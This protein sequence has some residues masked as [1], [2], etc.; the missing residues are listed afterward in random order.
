MLYLRL[1]LKFGSYVNS[2][3]EIDMF[4]CLLS[5]PQALPVLLQSACLG[6]LQGRSITC[7][8]LAIH[9]V[10]PSPPPL[11]D[12]ADSA[13][14]QGTLPSNSQV[15]HTAGQLRLHRLQWLLAGQENFPSAVA[16]H[17][18]GFSTSDAAQ[19]CAAAAS[20]RRRRRQPNTETAVRDAISS[21]AQRAEKLYDG[22]SHLVGVTRPTYG[23][24]GLWRCNITVKLRKAYVNFELECLTHLEAAVACDLL[25]CAVYGA[26]YPANFPPHLYPPQDVAVMKTHLQATVR[27]SRLLE[28]AL[29]NSAYRPP[30]RYQARAAGRAADAAVRAA[31]EAAGLSESDVQQRTVTG[32]VVVQNNSFVARQWRSTAV[33]EVTGHETESHASVRMMQQRCYNSMLQA[34]VAYD[35]MRQALGRSAVNF[36]AEVTS[37]GVP[38]MR[39]WMDLD[40]NRQ[41]VEKQYWKNKVTAAT[42]DNSGQKPRG[43]ASRGRRA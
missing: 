1:D 29:I 19:L 23:G 42:S 3:S 13:H 34:A 38:V 14:Q 21:L 40:M 39:K 12:T 35:M 11:L 43:A 24:S 25:K 18:R 31:I 6:L 15:Q 7:T 22:S 16:R 20:S 28:A 33:A 26:D 10:Q 27:H 9:P 30:Q 5:V 41:T 8:S 2:G 36:P 37:A 32:C 4:C 17:V